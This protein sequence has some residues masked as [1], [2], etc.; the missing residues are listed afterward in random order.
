[1]G[2]KK[3][4]QLAELSSHLLYLLPKKIHLNKAGTEK[5]EKVSEQEYAVPEGSVVGTDLEI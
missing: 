3:W 4:T 5:E 2:S 1:M